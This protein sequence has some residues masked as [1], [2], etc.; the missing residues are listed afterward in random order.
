[1]R[2]YFIP[3]F[4]VKSNYLKR[5]LHVAGGDRRT[6]QELLCKMYAEQH[7]QK[8]HNIFLTATHFSEEHLL[9]N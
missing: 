2:K 6:K 9:H 3:E 8:W 1:M 5:H 7:E 4:S